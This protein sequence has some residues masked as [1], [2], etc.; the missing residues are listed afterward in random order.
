MRYEIC[1][2]SPFM[3][4]F[5]LRPFHSCHIKCQS[6]I[7]KEREREIITKEILRN[8][9]CNVIYLEILSRSNSLSLQKD[10]FSF[11][12]FKLIPSYNNMPK[13]LL[14]SRLCA[15]WNTVIKYFESFY[16]EPAKFKIEESSESSSLFYFLKLLNCLDWYLPALF[17]GRN[18]AMLFSSRD[19]RWQQ[20]RIVSIYISD[21]IA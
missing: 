1:R 19:R 21:T 4:K 13:L 10:L 12:F 5:H 15:S 7:E 17:T 11:V 9:D 8:A 3:H 16:S 6:F 14:T 18:G 20:M 2:L